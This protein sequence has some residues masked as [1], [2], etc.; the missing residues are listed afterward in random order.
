MPP[1]FLAHGKD[2]VVVPCNSS[3]KLARKLK[4]CCVDYKFY[5]HKKGNHAFEFVLK[6]FKTIRI[7][8]ATSSFLKSRLSMSEEPMSDT[9]GKGENNAC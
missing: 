5:V 6:D 2:D 9:E 1:V 7:L 8:E 4:S 3:I